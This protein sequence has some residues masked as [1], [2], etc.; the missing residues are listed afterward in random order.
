MACASVTRRE[1][2][3]IM[4]KMFVSY[5]DL[6][7]VSVHFAEKGTVTAT[8]IAPKRRGRWIQAFGWRLIAIGMN[9]MCGHCD[10]KIKEGYTE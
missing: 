9:I 8:A 4:G 6:A 1:R 10:W 2:G 7:T 3:K 5:V